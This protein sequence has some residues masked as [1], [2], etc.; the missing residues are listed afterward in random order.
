MQPQPPDP[1]PSPAAD[2]RGPLFLAGGVLCI[3]F[4]ALFVKVSGLPPTAA[5]LHRMAGS[6]ALLLIYALAARARP[7]T[8]AP[9]R[10]TAALALLLMAVGGVAFA[11]DMAVWNRSILRVGPGMATLLANL[12]VFIVPLI[13]A[14]MGGGWPRKRFWLAAAAGLTGL[15]L[16][17]LPIGSLGRALDPVGL[18]FGLAAA[19][20]YS[21]YIAFLGES[22][23]RWALGPPLTLLIVCASGTL[24]LGALQAVELLLDPS[25]RVLARAPEAW[26]GVAGMVLITQLGGW[27]LLLRGIQRVGAAAAGVALVGQSVLA[28]LWDVLLLGRQLN[29]QELTGAAVVLLAIAVGYTAARPRG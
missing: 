3:S 12:Q 20:T 10:R 26:L 8:P 2:W 25:A 24:A 18:L 23:R 9:A 17:A 19:A 16:L 7:A 1:P 27:S 4:A 28:T 21:V 11:G 13:T 22:T 6:T 14:A 29:A 15:A 5:G